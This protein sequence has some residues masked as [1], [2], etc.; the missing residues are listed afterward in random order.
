MIEVD[1]ERFGGEL[2]GVRVADLDIAAADP[3]HAVVVGAVDA[4][5]VHRV[6]V[7]AGIDEVDAEEIA[8]VGAQGRTRH[9][10]VVGPGREKDARRDLDL[11]V[12]GD[13]L[14][15]AHDRA[16]GAGLGHRAVVEIGQD[17]DGVPAEPGDIDIAD[18]QVVVVPTVLVLHGVPPCW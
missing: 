2:V 18:G 12:V 8:L 16:V 7:A 17:I 13:D 4:V 5:E 3:G 1:A 9:A 15:L 6:R 10:A 11:L 14:P